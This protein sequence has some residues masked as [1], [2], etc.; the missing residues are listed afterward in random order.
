LGA[1]QSEFVPESGP[2]PDWFATAGALALAPNRHERAGSPPS[3]M[4]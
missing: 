3:V 2:N 4:L 1:N